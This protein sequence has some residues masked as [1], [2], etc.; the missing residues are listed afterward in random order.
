MGCRSSLRRESRKIRT[1]LLLCM[2]DNIHTPSL[3]VP[4]VH[5]TYLFTKCVTESCDSPD[6]LIQY[7]LSSASSRVTETVSMKIDWFSPLHWLL[8]L[9][10]LE[11][12]YNENAMRRMFSKMFKF[13]QYDQSTAEYRYTYHCYDLATQND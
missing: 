6:W 11:P 4:T 10:N 1:F 7:C 13:V 5:V 2:F 8:Y 3:R 9:N 12:V